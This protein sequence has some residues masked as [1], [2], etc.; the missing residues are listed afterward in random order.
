MRRALEYSSI[1]DLPIIDHC[2]DPSLSHDAVM[3]EGWVSTRLGL[4]GASAAREET[5]IE[6]LEEAVGARL[7]RR[8]EDPFTYVPFDE[9]T[10]TE[11]RESLGDRAQRLRSQVEGASRRVFETAPHADA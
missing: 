3:H 10:G 7:I 8:G 5:M 9:R 2:E 1:F 11:I 6:V 4:R